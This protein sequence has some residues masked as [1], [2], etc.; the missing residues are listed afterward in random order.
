M[1]I[2]NTIAVELEI[3]YFGD[4]FLDTD[5]FVGEMSGETLF[6]THGLGSLDRDNH[7]VDPDLASVGL[8]DLQCLTIRHFTYLV[9][10][11]VG[12]FEIHVGNLIHGLLPIIRYAA[13]SQYGAEDAA[14]GCGVAVG[15]VTATGGYVNGSVVILFAVEERSERVI[16]TLRT[17]ALI[18][19]ALH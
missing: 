6:E 11:Y 16:S 14:S 12:V 1:I 18:L 9:E 19:M 7:V 5:V 4:V 17:Y 8:D 15:I 2:I 3:A 13:E 10:G